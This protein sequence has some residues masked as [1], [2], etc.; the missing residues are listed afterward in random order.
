MLEKDINDYIT[1]HDLC[2]LLAS[3]TAELAKE[4][5]KFD[6]AYDGRVQASVL[7]E[8]R[9]LNG[10]EPDTFNSPVIPLLDA[11]KYIEF[12][13]INQLDQTTL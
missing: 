2:E 6:G 4:M 3:D 11:I 5:D 8:W 10:L 1:L 9:V 12:V 7:N 13:K